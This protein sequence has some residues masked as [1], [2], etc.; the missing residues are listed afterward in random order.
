MTSNRSQLKKLASLHPPTRYFSAKAFIRQLHADMKQACGS[1]SYRQ[2]ADDL[3]FSATN[4]VHLFSQ[5]RRPISAQAAKRIADAL[6]LRKEHRQYFLR[7][8]QM[9]QNL[10]AEEFAQVFA[11]ALEIRASLITDKLEREQLQFYSHWATIVIREMLVLP[12]FKL[13]AK[14]IASKLWPRISVK[15]AEEAIALL[16]KLEL[17][18]FDRSSK[19]WQQRAATVS[20]GPEVASLAVNKYHQLSIPQGLKSLVDVEQSRRHISSLTLAVNERQFDLIKKEIEAFQQ[21]LL[22]LEQNRESGPPDRVVQLNM[23]LFPNT[24]D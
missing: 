23:Q 5:G 7:L 20:T 16:K 4:V 24:L 22:E 18:Q 9:T 6:A 21:R 15:E 11:E 3:G 10:S 14:W 19:T 12:D 2:L 13:E 17:I 8:A 1:Y